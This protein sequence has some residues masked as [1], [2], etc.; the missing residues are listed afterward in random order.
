[1]NKTI[2]TKHYKIGDDEPCYII[3]EIGSN[4]NGS[5][6]IACELIEKASQAGAN[7][8]KFQ[9][10]KA[11]NHYSKKTPRLDLYEQDIYDLIESLEI[12]RKWHVDL[13]KYCKDLKIDFL[14]SPCDEE[15]IKLAL[16]VDMP[17]MKIASFDMVDIDLIKKI[18]QTGKS[19]MF[20]TGMAKLSEIEKAVEV[21]HKENNDNIIILQCTSLY[22]APSSL[23]NLKAITTLKYAFNTIVGYSDHT[24]GDHMACA[25]ICFGAKVIEKHYTLDRGLPG[26]DHNFAI[27]PEELREM[28]SKIREVESG[29]G[30]GLKNGPREEEKEMYKI[31]RRSLIAARDISAGHTITND[32][33]VI[34]RPGLGIHPHFKRAILGRICKAAIDKDDPII[35]E[36]I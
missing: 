14:D 16:S 32:D 36:N 3:A 28:I 15:A 23:A 35:W 21:C 33:I 31:V 27:Q 8:V 9:T 19:L 26:P 12:D 24:I 18:S 11:K 13:S 30:N 4:H 1:M 34:K 17:I 5:Y 7:A 6:D 25:S 10:F 22:P 29:L 2:Q 20:S